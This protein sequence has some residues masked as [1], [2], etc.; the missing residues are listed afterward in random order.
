MQP[1]PCAAPWF[2]GVFAS[3]ALS[4][5]PLLWRQEVSVLKL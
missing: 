5:Q 1:E 4:P 2:T 3:S